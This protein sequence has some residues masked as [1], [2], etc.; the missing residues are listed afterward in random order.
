MPSKSRGTLRRERGRLALAKLA[1]EE[2]NL[3]LLD[4]P[5]T[6]RHPSQE[7]SSSDGGLRWND[8]ARHA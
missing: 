5:P 7:I 6:T 4:E 2:T 3:L 1:L 8:P